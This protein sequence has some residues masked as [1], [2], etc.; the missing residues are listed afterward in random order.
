MTHRNPLCLAA[1]T[2]ATLFLCHTPV[3]ADLVMTRDNTAVYTDTDYTQSLRPTLPERLFTSKAIEKEIV[4]IKR[5]LTNEKLAWM[6]ENC[7]PNTLDTAV[8]FRAIDGDDDTFVYT[9]DIHAMWLRDSASEVWPYLAFVSKDDEL[10][11]MIRGVILRQFKCILIDPYANAFSDGPENSEVY[12]RRWELDSPCHCLRLAYAYWKETGDKS[13]FTDG[14]WQEVM[15]LILRTFREQQ[16]KD[17]H[18]PYTYHHADSATNTPASDSRSMHPVRPTGLIASAFHPSDDPATLQFII[19]SNFFAVTSLRK[20]DEILRKV[21]HDNATADACAALANEVEEALHHHAIVEHPTYGRIYAYEVDGF[22]NYLMMD[23]A[24]VPGLLSMPYLGDVNPND[25]VYLNTRRFV[26]SE[27]NP[28]FFRGNSGEGIGSSRTGYDMIR[29]MSLLVRALTSS[30]DAEIAACLRMLIGTDAETG[31]IHES[32]HKDDPTHY[33]RA[34]FARQNS[35]FGELI[36][37]L[38]HEKKFELLDD[39]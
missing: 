5:T 25:P 27:D 20:A 32:F 22:G 7:F 18:G 6:F 11:Q 35:L 10:R 23:D 8:H 16:H 19:P 17:G 4:R 15:R 39:L 9:G 13:I 37:K 12:E 38:V 2:A 34:W 36:V 29:P 33:T 1:A 24:D 3:R 26:W 30:D 28:Y 21:N 14:K 31:F